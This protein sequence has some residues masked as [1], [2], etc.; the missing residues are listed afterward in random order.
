MKVLIVILLFIYVNG[1]AQT[2]TIL[3]RKQRGFL[4]LSNNNY[5]YDYGGSHSRPLGFHDFFFPI[6]CLNV[7]CFSDSNM[8]IIYKRGLRIDL[9]G[10][11]RKL[12]KKRAAA[13]SCIDTSNCYEFDKFYVI[14]VT[15]DYK[16]FEDY[17]PFV[18]RRNYFELRVKD[19]CNLRFE[20]L[21]KAINPVVITLQK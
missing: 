12:L 20:Y 19:G 8:S 9:V 15:I 6:N 14:P 5:L 13:Y 3:I 16:M 7:N 21:H 11:K 17:E 18:C 10:D 2:D 4:F 1:F